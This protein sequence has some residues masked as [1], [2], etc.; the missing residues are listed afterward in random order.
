AITVLKGCGTIIATPT[1]D[2]YINHSGN[3]GLATA[4]M[5]DA[6]AG[7]IAALVAQ[8][9]SPEQATLLG[10]HI[11]GA[12]ADALVEHGVGPIGLTASEVMMEVRRI[13]NQWAEWGQA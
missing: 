13:L 12:A 7:I 11:H 2:W 10:V 3:P 6:L 8:K 9:I 4:G 1:G 5:G